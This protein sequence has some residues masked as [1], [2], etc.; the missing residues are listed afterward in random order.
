MPP[1]RATNFHVADSRHK[2]RFPNKFVVGVGPGG[3]GGGVVTTLVEANM[4]LD[5]RYNKENRRKNLPNVEISGMNSLYSNLGSRK[6]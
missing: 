1:P 2:A 3:G 6:S 5:W 4:N